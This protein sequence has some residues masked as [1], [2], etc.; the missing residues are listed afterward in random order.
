MALGNTLLK[1][2]QG[3]GKD[4]EPT[5]VWTGNGYHIYLPLQPLPISLESDPMFSTFQNASKEFQKFAVLYIADGKSDPNNKPMFAAS[6]VRIPRSFLQSV[7]KNPKSVF[8]KMKW[9]CT[10]NAIGNAD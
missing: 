7:W 1:I 9:D 4:I 6:L 2:K 8:S 3:F 5:V 10:K